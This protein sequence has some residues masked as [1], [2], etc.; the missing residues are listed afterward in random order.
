M[1]PKSLGKFSFFGKKEKLAIEM[2]LKEANAATDTVKSL[3]NVVIA[4]SQG[5]WQ[6]V[7]AASEGVSRLEEKVDL[8]HREAMVL[9][10]EG[11]FFAGIRED[12]LNL[13]EQIDN[14]A[15]YSK[16]A[17]RILAQ[18]PIPNEVYR[19][20]FS[21]D[22]P[23]MLIKK[24][25]EAMSILIDGIKSLLSEPKQALKL[26]IQVERDEEEG[27][28]IKAHIIRNIFFR[29]TELD[30]LTLLE[31]KDFILWLDNVL[32]GIEDASD[33]IIIITAKSGV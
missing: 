6:D 8:I 20:I 3:E 30:V 11:A 2:I 12:I 18:F 13:M 19:T 21:Q 23:I 25:E 32:D 28:E 5:N 33:V 1:W 31:L 15:D 7:N 14:V 9:V 24:A 10:S 27:D 17:S 26:A 22:D 4:A 29:K 16:D